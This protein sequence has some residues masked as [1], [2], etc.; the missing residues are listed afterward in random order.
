MPAFDKVLFIDDDIIT[1][2]ICERLIKLT[3]FAAEFVSCED[4][5]KAQTFLMKNTDNLPDLIFVDLNMSV[6][7]GW[8]FIEWFNVWSET[9]TKDIPVYIFSSSLYKEDYDRASSYKTAG[10]IIKPI[11][12][13]HLSKITAKYAST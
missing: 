9:I 4:G 5:S 12:V 10:F 7:N 8:E 11:T 6:M 2:K 3:D 13:E 1:V